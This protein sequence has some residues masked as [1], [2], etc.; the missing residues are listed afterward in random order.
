[1]YLLLLPRKTADLIGLLNSKEVED[2]FPRI[3]ERRELAHG[4]LD[5]YF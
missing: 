2:I 3:E 4:V 1:M 5:P